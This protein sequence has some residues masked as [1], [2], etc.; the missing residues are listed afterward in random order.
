[1]DGHPAP[2][3]VV[4]RFHAIHDSV[5]VDQL[6]R[7][8]ELKAILVQQDGR[9]HLLFGW[10]RVSRTAQSCSVS[11]KGRS[12]PNISASRLQRRE[13]RSCKNER[14]HLESQSHARHLGG[15]I[16]EVSCT[17][18]AGKRKGEPVGFRSSKEAILRCALP[19]IS[20]EAHCTTLRGATGLGLPY[21]D[22]MVPS[23]RER[24][25]IPV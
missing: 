3:I 13:E 21:L 15:R 14:P 25:V 1:M 5:R 23:T 8:V 19:P 2:R 17:L 12:T 10:N 7:C 18:T 9:W 4:R 6:P 11:A 20:T 24:R 16:G 22:R